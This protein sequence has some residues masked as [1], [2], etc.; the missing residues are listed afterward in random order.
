MNR[1]VLI[2]LGGVVLV[3]LIAIMYFVFGG[4]K[5]NDKGN[6]IEAGCTI[7]PPKDVKVNREVALKI[8]A[9]LSKLTKMPASGETQITAKNTAEQTFQL[10]SDADVACHMLLQTINCLSAKPGNE[11]TVQSLVSYLKEGDKCAPQAQPKNA[12]QLRIQGQPTVTNSDQFELDLGFVE[13]EK[14]LTIPITLIA[15]LPGNPQLKVTLAEQPLTASWQSGGDAVVANEQTP[16]VLIVSIP[17]QRAN[18]EMRSELRVSATSTKPMPTMT[19]AVHLQSLPS[20]QAVSERSGDK[21][22]GRGKD[23]SDVYTVCARAPSPGDYVHESHDY[24][25][26]GDRNCGSWAKCDVKVDPSLK[27]VCLHFTLQGHDECLR[28]FANCDATRESEGHI[29][30]TF[31]L[32]PSTPALRAI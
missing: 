28:P 22:S 31:R 30:A 16:A 14:E 23:Y 15:R 18:T 13:A 21:R 7:T 12:Y 29:R 19:L 17:P 25:L 8:A 4:G 20:R 10:I 32:V 24:R 2:A 1:N 9:D 26:S 3:A 27:Q 11:A 5:R 6:P